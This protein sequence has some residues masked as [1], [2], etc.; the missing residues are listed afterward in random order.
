MIVERAGAIELLAAQQRRLADI[1][2]LGLAQHLA[3][4]HLDVLVVDLHA[5]QAIH[6]LDLANQVVGQRL[7]A[8]QAQDVVRVRLAVGDDFAA[9]HGLAFEHVELAPL[10]N[11]LLVLLAVVAG[12]DQAALALGLLAEADRA[13][14]SPRG[15]PGPS[16]CGPRTGPRR[17]ADRR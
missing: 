10:R 17:A 9:L 15:S 5:L 7:D 3:D 6:V 14:T 4:D 1:L 12:D 13:A 16:A 2:H 8:L 11:Q